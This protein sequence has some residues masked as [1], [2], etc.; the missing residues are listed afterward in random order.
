MQFIEWS[1][2]N[3]TNAGNL[4]TIEVGKE[5]NVDGLYPVTL[6]FSNQIGT[7]EYGKTV[8]FGSK[9]E[10]E[11]GVQEIKELFKSGRDFTECTL[12][13]LPDVVRDLIEDRER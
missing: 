12:D 13:D 11:V 7:F 8:Y 6:Y 3:I 10:Q 5:R 1:N 9:E 4:S 2:G